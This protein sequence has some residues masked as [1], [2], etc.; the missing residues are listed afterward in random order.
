[1]KQIANFNQKVIMHAIV[2]IQGFSKDTLKVKFK[3]NWYCEISYCE[4]GFNLWSVGGWLLLSSPWCWSCSSDNKSIKQQRE[5]T[6]L[7]SN[8]DF[9][10]QLSKLKVILNTHFQS[11]IV[12]LQIEK[13]SFDLGECAEL[14]FQTERIYTGWLES[15]WSW[16]LCILLY[17]SLKIN[18]V[19]HQMRPWLI[20][21]N[22]IPVW[23]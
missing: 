1:M 21:N 11:K 4:N 12:W 23:D 5:S 13:T 7:T 14:G 6:S 22:H 17:G 18:H 16:Q 10:E 15:Q 2:S 9:V 8:H 3:D 19:N 20:M